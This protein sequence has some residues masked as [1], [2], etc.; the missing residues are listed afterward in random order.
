LIERKDAFRLEIWDKSFEKLKES[1]IFGHGLGEVFSLEYS[2]GSVTHPHNLYLYV[3]YT[4]GLVCLI[5]VLVLYFMAI[6]SIY[7]NWDADY[8]AFMAAILIYIVTFNFFNSRMIIDDIGVGWHLFWLPIGM[9][10]S[11]SSF[12]DTVRADI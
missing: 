6:N 1:I 7:R 2:R 9:I 3:V 5:L 4:G 8:G 10:A 12:R 11:F